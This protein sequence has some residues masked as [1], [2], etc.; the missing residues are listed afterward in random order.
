MTYST[1]RQVLKVR[2]GQAATSRLFTNGKHPQVM[3]SPC[4]TK[5]YI[6]IDTMLYMAY[7]FSMNDDEN[8][9]IHNDGKSIDDL[10]HSWCIG[11]ITAN[12][13]QDILS[14]QRRINEA[15]DAV[16]MIKEPVNAE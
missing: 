10:V 6:A 13:F 15:K 4:C 12:E 2:D 14:V 8:L 11:E 5:V 16:S 7:L 3:H 1:S 9:I